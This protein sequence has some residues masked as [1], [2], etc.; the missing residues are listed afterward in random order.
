MNGEK[1]PP[2]DRP[3]AGLL[4]Y[5]DEGSETGGLIFAGHKNSQGQVVHCCG[6]LSFDR[7]GANQFVQLAGV[8]DSTD[9]FAGF[10]VA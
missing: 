9:R 6:S 7:Y 5:N 8:D 10:P 2:A 3:Q 1:R 4:F